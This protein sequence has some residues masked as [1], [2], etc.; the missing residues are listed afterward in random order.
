MTIWENPLN[1]F[2]LPDDCRYVIF[3]EEICPDT[4]KKHWQSYCELLKPMRM[5]A[6]KKMFKDGTMH[7]ETRMGTRDQA[8]DYCKKDGK[9]T[10]YGKW[11]SGQGHRSDLDE[12]V[13]ALT[14]GTKRVT[15][16]MIDNPQTY[17]RYRNG[18][19]DIQ[20][21][22]D[23]KKNSDFR[24]IEVTIITGPTGCGKT[25]KA[26]EEATFKIEGNT[27]KWWNGYDNDKVICIDEYDND[28]G[29]TTLLNLLDGYKLRLETKGGFTYAG[30]NK[31]I[32]TTNLRK[33]QIHCNA[34][35]AHREALN[36]RVTKW[37]D[38]WD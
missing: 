11:I 25:R 34:K 3:G 16:I 18:L 33:E 29:I 30:W 31:V 4:G 13:E 32:I 10:E 24:K 21:S 23:K 26:M 17:C 37:V 15:D 27:L 22:I 19:N 8:R 14:S 12:I 35:P 9:F 20:A 7:L 6:V 1:N 38:M 5:S 2:V 36:R 28:V